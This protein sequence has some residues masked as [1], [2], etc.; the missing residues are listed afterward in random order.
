MSLRRQ[1]SAFG[2]FGSGASHRAPAPTTRRVRRPI[3]NRA[4]AAPSNALLTTVGIGEVAA[5]RQV[6]VLRSV[7]G[8]CVSVCLF[9][10]ETCIGGMNHILIPSS[11][12]SDCGS[13]CGVQAMELLINALMT[14]GADRRRFVAKIFGG[15]NVLPVI[16][17]PSVG[18]LN[19][20]FVRSFLA[21]ER[22]PLVAERIG[23]KKP[24]Q[25]NFHAHT[26]KAFVREIDSLQLTHI[27]REEIAYYKIKPEERYRSEDPILF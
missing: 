11:S 12:K 8:S 5:S 21:T 9:D 14:L 22:I 13:R 6:A 17:Q 2:W 27:V 16:Q 26:G 15:A 23:G 24:V 7:L 20:R 3:V 25:V 10:P 18:E 1:P 4:T 19:I